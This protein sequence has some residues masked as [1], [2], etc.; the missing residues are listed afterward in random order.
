MV[1]LGK[2]DEALIPVARLQEKY[3]PTWGR[4]VFYPK[5]FYLLGKL[6]EKK[7]DKAQAIKSYEKLLE[8]WKNADRDL[9]EL[10][11]TQA[12]LIRLKGNNR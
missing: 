9:P 2:L 10:I 5:S 6:C 4:A 3:V 11:D 1:K 8:L 7:G 12:R